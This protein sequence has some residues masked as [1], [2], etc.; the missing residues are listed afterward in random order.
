MKKL[1]LVLVLALVV[2]VTWATLREPSVEERLQWDAKGKIEACWELQQRKSMDP[3]QARGVARLCE[4][5]EANYMRQYG[6]K[7]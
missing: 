6:R 1:L 4:E 3:A 7:P 5:M 2:F